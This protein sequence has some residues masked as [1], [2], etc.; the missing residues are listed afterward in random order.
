MVHFVVSLKISAQILTFSGL[1]ISVLSLKYL[2]SFDEDVC[3][4]KVSVKAVISL[5]P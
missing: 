3:L 5:I 1:G 2:H 4:E